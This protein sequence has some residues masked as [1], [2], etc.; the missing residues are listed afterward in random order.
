MAFKK[1]DADAILTDRSLP[2]VYR[3]LFALAQEFAILG[4][5]ETAKTMISLLLSE[6]TSD[7]Q[8]RQ[9]RYLRL[10]FAE[11]NQWPEEISSDERTEEALN[12]IEPQMPPNVNYEALDSQNDAAKLETLLKHADGEDATT[13][14]GAMQ[15]SSTLADALVVAIRIASE[16]A[17]SLE[18]I[19]NHEKVQ[20]V[21]GHIS[22]R[23]SANQQ[24]QYLTERRSI[25]P[26]LLSGALSRSIPVDT[27]KVNALAKDVID[28][29][30]ERLKNGR[31]A[32]PVETKSIKELL[33]ELE[34][35]TVANV[36]RDALEFG[37]E[38]P[39][40]LFIF[41]PATDGQVSALEHKLN[42]KLPNDYKEFLKLS[43][44]FGRTWNG[45]YLDPPLDGVDDIDWA[46]VYTE[47]APIALH[48][49][50]TGNFDLDLSEEGEWP[51]YEKA[52]QLGTED[53]FDYWFLPPQET[54]KALEAYR[55]VLKTPEVSEE[56]KT[57]TIKLITSKYRSWEAF[58]KL[59]WVVVEM[60]HGE[61][62]S[63][64]SFTQFLQEKVN[65][66]AKGMWQGEGEIEEG[67]FSY[68]CKPS[69]N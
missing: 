3:S 17:S 69:G 5:I 62:T 68:S 52:L 28:T 48:E 11:A 7:W 24:I 59:E 40:S 34:R 16:H 15:R 41:P 35:N 32:H 57:Q 39:E 58:E 18:G 13:G 26:L 14:G 66:S 25:W 30:T 50:P 44:G 10:A 54:K 46:D 27:N 2:D 55:E 20:E 33:I 37:G 19:E 9:I 43:N 53:I 56:K 31:K 63:C 60:S 42:T 6:Y 45:Y 61:D 51:I 29:F 21:L 64:G 49:T 1:F 65:R 67:C 12:K 8:R 4:H 22:K 47:D 36:E 38:V 23:L